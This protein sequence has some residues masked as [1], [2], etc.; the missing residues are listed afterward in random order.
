MLQLPRWENTRDGW[1]PLRAWL[2]PGP[3]HM[4]QLLPLRSVAELN[5]G[6]E[7]PGD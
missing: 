7:E 1:I 2:L 6:V 3:P 5:M 4:W